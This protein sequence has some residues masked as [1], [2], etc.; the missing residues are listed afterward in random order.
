MLDTNFDCNVLF[1]LWCITFWIFYIAN[2]LQYL[3]TTEMICAETLSRITI[4][5][6]L[7]D[8]TFLVGIWHMWS[9]GA[10]DHKNCTF[11]DFSSVKIYF[12]TKC[13][14]LVKRQNKIINNNIVCTERSIPPRAD[15]YDGRCTT[16]LRYNSSL[17]YLLQSHWLSVLENADKIS[18]LHWRVMVHYL[19]FLCHGEFRNGL[20]QYVVCVVYVGHIKRWWTTT[21]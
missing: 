3:S 1:R 20:H 4:K 19:I 11:C 16:K 8:R 5:H 2:I 9:L 10:D 15:L 21:G 12:D 17:V 6:L 7:T 14:I 13:I 18:W